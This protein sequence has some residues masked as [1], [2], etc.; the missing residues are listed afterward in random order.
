MLGICLNCGNT[1]WDKVVDGN[2]IICPKCG[3][4]RTFVKLP[5]YVITGCSGIGKTTTAVALQKLTRDFIIQDVDL[6]YNVMQPQTEEENLDMLEQVFNI[7]KNMTQSGKPVVWT[8]AGSIDKL[9]HTYGKRFFSEIKVLALTADSEIIRKRMKEGRG[10]TD[11]NWIESSVNY[12]EYFRTHSTI[13]DTSFETL[14]CSEGTPA[15]IAEKV[16]KWLEKNDK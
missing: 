13:G 12:N 1:E 14:D 6:F 2:K 15:E 16:L 5:F 4:A 11:E 7:S 9:P 8:M 10:I 3:A